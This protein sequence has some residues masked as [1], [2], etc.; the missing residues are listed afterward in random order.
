MLV[1]GTF[2]LPP[3]PW[4]PEAVADFAHSIDGVAIVAHPFR[5]YG[6]GERA[7]SLK[8]RR[9]RGPK[10]GHQQRRQRKSQRIRPKDWVHGE[11]QAAMPIRFPNCLVFARKLRRR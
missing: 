9:N 8:V 1:L 2:E 6:M 11:P 3:K 7:R 4:T 10:R 5:T